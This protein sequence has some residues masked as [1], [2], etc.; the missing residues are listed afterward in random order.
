MKSLLTVWYCPGTHLHMWKRG[1]HP[2]QTVHINV[3]VLDRPGPPGGP[4]S[5][6]GVT[7]EKAC[8]AWRPP[9]QDGGS[10]VSHYI[11]EKRETSR[12]VWTLVEPKVQTLNLKI[13]KLVPGN[14]YVFRV[15]PVNKYG[16][17]EPLESEPMISRNQFVTPDPP[18][19]VEVSTITKD[20]MV[21]T[22]ERPEKDGGNAI[23]GF[24]IEKRDKEGVRWTR[25]NKR[26]V[27]ELRFRVAGLL[28]NRS[29]EF[30][31]SSENAAG[32]G[33]PSEPTIY[34][35]A[36]DAIFTSG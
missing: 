21:V 30:R 7:S 27:S 13:I 1:K 28:E 24:V 11:V 4:I 6:Y 23:S 3:K 33:K 8:I 10:D 31:V 25:C 14:E 20:S 15:I 36:L 5:I 32:V 26:T 18:T 2:P 9:A 19:D 35:K 17:G 22:W 16:I 29:Y 34:Y 12:L